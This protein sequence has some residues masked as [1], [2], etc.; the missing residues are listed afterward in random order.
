MLLADDPAPAREVVSRL[1]PEE[2]GLHANG[3]FAR[4]VLDDAWG[5]AE[6][7]RSDAAMACELREGALREYIAALD[8]GERLPGR[9]N[10]ILPFALC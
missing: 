2:I 1:R 7:T 8:A 4:H 6:A 3:W 10:W 5:T 9:S